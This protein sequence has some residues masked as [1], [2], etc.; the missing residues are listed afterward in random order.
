[1]WMKLQSRD[2]LAKDVDKVMTAYEHLISGIKS[3]AEVH[4]IPSMVTLTQKKAREEV[5]QYIQSFLE[6]IR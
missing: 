1:M 4:H 6:P 2:E 3:M 5:I